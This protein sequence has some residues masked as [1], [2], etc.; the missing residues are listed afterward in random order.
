MRSFPR[1]PIPA[2]DLTNA[3]RRLFTAV[4]NVQAKTPAPQGVTLAPVDQALVDAVRAS[5]AAAV[6]AAFKNG[7]Q[8]NAGFAKALQVASENRNE[9]LMQELVIRGADV[10][11]AIAGLK[12]EQK[13]LSPVKVRHDDPEVRAAMEAML[14]VL[15]PAGPRGHALPSDVDMLLNELDRQLAAKRILASGTQ[16]RLNETK[17]AIQTLEEWNARFLKEIA[18]VE[19]LRQQR[20][21]LDQL[22][23]MRRDM[24]PGKLDKPKFTGPKKPPQL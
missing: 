11:A 6:D 15:A 13:A 9:A 22:A 5:D 16:Q 1:S 24:L 4:E 18:P 17:A 2:D 21:I 12:A 19:I 14:G 7:A 20:Q 8:A 3:V 23:E 10:A